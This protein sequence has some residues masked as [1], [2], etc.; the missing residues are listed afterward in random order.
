VIRRTIAYDNDNAREGLSIG[1]N[2]SE[3]PNRDVR[4]GSNE[5]DIWSRRSEADPVCPMCGEAVLA[6]ALECPSCGEMLPSAPSRKP[7]PEPVRRRHGGTVILVSLLCAVL[8]GFAG[9]LFARVL[10]G[11]GGV[12]SD[13][14]YDVSA[15]VGAFAGGIAG[16]GC[17]EYFGW[18]HDQTARGIIW[19]VVFL[20]FLGMCLLSLALR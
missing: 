3:F 7:V 10:Y 4:N 12:A 2:R 1:M 15:A 14:Y 16:W 11:D 6:D 9:L 17:C 18:H 5:I 20:L 8:G 19:T 13:F